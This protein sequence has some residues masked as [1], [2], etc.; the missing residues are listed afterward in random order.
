MNA[1]SAD[2]YDVYCKE[3]ETGP[4]SPFWDEALAAVISRFIEMPDDPKS[5]SE[6]KRLCGRQIEDYFAQRGI[7][8][9]PEMRG[10]VDLRIAKAILDAISVRVRRVLDNDFA[11]DPVEAK[12]QRPVGSRSMLKL[13]DAFETYAQTVALSAATRKRWLPALRTLTVHSGTNDLA[14]IT[15]AHVGTWIEWLRADGK[16]QRTI[17]DRVSCLGKGTVPLLRG[18]AEARE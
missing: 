6:F 13:D 11:A 15:D 1:Y 16:S 5:H 9:V 18:R 3:I 12:Y 14:R 10:A 7:R 4:W 8:I 2:F 17:K